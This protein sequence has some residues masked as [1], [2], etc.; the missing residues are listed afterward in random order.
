MKVIEVRRG[1]MMHPVS[2]VLCE[3]LIYFMDTGHA[4]IVYQGGT[5]SYRS[6]RVGGGL[7][8]RVLDNTSKFSRQMDLAVDAYVIET[9]TL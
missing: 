5:R 9:F 7:G 1:R 2:M 8:K 4:A 3:T 6:K